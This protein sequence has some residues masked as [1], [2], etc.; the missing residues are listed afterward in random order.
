M[1]KEA[2]EVTQE[3]DVKDAVKAAMDY[4]KELYGSPYADLALEEVEK[5]GVNWLITLGY[6]MARLGPGG[7][8]VVVAPGATRQFKLIT[9]DSRTG[10]V[11]SMKVKKF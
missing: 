10:E 8:G 6:L 7:I 3:I 11:K 4:F 9:V 2:E 5:T 1:A